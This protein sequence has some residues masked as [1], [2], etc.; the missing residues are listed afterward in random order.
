MI[1]LIISKK[2]YDVVAGRISNQIDYVVAEKIHN[3]LTDLVDKA[4][5]SAV[6]LN[7]IVAIKEKLR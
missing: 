5:D 2:L 6:G 4:V 1:D 3:N 7:T